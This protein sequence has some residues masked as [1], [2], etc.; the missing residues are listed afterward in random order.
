MRDRYIQKWFSKEQVIFRKLQIYFLYSL[1]AGGA[2][3][4]FKGGTALDIFYGSGRFSEDLDFD[5]KT[6]D[7]LVTV[8][9]AIDF[10]KQKSEYAVFNDW[11]KE[12]EMHRDFIRYILRISS[13]EIDNIISFLIDYTVDTPIYPP[14]R[15]VIKYNDSLVN[16]NVMQMKE[17]LPEKVSAILNREKARDLYDLYYLA[18]VKRVPISLKDIYAKCGK[19][20][21]TSRK[22]YSFELFKKRVNDLKRRWSEMDVLLEDPKNYPFEEVSGSVL[23]LFKS[24]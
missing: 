14:N 17:I 15:I 9:R 16:A 7:D 20:F 24:L 10:L 4:I 2:N 22:D 23:E 18:V 12:R 21:S 3:L 19:N 11:E 1:Y 8:D 13:K 5:G 6:L